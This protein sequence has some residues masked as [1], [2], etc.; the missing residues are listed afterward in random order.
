[1]ALGDYSVF[2]K[3]S[4]R[5]DFSRHKTRGLFP[6]IGIV[7]RAPAERDA[8]GVFITA[9]AS[10]PYALNITSAGRRSVAKQDF[11]KITYV[12]THFKSRCTAEKINAISAR[13]L[14]TEPIFNL[15]GEILVNLSGVLLGFQARKLWLSYS[16]DPPRYNVFL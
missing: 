1:M 9:S 4:R 12:N 5:S 13:L 3:D 10:A 2:D 6:G 16:R 7:F 15:L 14:L 11:L 8:Y